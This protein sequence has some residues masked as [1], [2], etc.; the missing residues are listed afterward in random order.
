MF[1][2]VLTALYNILDFFFVGWSIMKLL[3]KRLERWRMLPNSSLYILELECHFRIFLLLFSSCLLVLLFEFYS[4]P[5]VF[6]SEINSELCIGAGSGWVMLVLILILHLLHFLLAINCSLVLN[7][8]CI[9]LFQ[10]LWQKKK[11][12]IFIFAFVN[13]EL[14]HVW[15]GFWVPNLFLHLLLFRFY[16]IQIYYF[17]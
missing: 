8:L 17:L 12:L 5:F 2:K 4:N 16:L 11:K 15:L 14:Y 7:E 10:L 1:K 3:E 13:E 9:C 6:S